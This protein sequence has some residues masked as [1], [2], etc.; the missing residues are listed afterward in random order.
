M[1]RFSITPDSPWLAP[2]AGYSDL[3]FRML[4]RK[5]GCGVACSEMVS[6]KGMAFKNSGTR[7]LI[8]T[9]PEDDP[10]VLQLFGSEAQYFH[11]VMEKLVGMGYRNFDLNAGCPVRKVLK[12]GSGVQLMEDLDKLVELAS[13]MVAKAAEHPEGG[14]VGVKFRLGFNKG[15]EVFLDLA[16]RL[17]DVG[18]NWVTLH[19][20]YGRQMFAGQANWAKLAELK[21]AVS[22]PVIGSGD[23]F[24]A[25]DGV[26]CIEETGIDAIMFARGALFDPPIFARYAALRNGSPLPVRD[27][28]FLAD[29]VCEHI[30]L[31]RLFEGDARSFRKIRSIIPRYAKG[32]RGIRSLR[33]SLLQ[34]E[35]WEDLEQAAAVIRDLQP[36]DPETDWP[37]VDEICR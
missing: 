19:P 14:R 37:P 29:I 26:R 28:A 22:I 34:C 20:R 16:R 23:L 35:T 31:T 24:S 13:I 4:V 8:A 2:L 32:L 17:E 30:R 10:M 1:N 12:S 15:E 11:P 25:E 27:G 21:K 6:V 36:A 7:R 18:V 33:A 9:C 3:P 5:Y